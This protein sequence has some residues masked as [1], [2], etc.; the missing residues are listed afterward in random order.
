M[1]N[2][3][4]VKHSNSMQDDSEWG[5]QVMKKTTSYGSLS[6]SD[7]GWIGERDTS[8]GADSGF[9]DKD[10]ERFNEEKRKTEMVFLNT[11][12]IDEDNAD[13]SKAIPADAPCY[14]VPLD[15]DLSSGIAGS[16]EDLT[17]FYNL[18]LSKKDEEE[19]QDFIKD[20]S[21]KNY[22]QLIRVYEEINRKGEELKRVHPMRFI[23]HILS[24][25]CSCE[26]LKT[27][28]RSFLKYNKFANGFQQ[29]MIEESKRENLLLYASG[30]AKHVNIEH[31]VVIQAIESK[32]YK[33]LI[34]KALKL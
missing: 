11:S 29:Q 25:S 20:L 17:H 10:L 33:D 24:D 8:W 13:S 21:V 3:S 23:G 27:L 26:H 7:S 15:S 4:S 6:G 22:Y 14:G 28:K 19:I 34:E 1:S 12:R 18:Q 2:L 16:P 32:N 31:T 5:F 9:L 30:F